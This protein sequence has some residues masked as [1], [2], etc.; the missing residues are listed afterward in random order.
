MNTDDLDEYIKENS[1]AYDIFIEKA[2]INQREKNATR[3]L[4]K[5]YTNER[6]EEEAQQMWRNIIKH[7]YGKLHSEPKL[8]DKS[9][10]YW[11]DFIL[12]NNLL[13]SLENSMFDLDLDEN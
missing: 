10:I 12:E 9:P 3:A 4:N 8:K 2:R 7:L 1:K 5:R 6:V 11:V 13:E